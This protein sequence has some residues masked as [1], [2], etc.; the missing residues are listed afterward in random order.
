[1]YQVHA[2]ESL[3][4][5]ELAPYRTMK[6]PIEHERQ[7]IFIAEGEKVVRRLLESQLTIISMLLPAKWLASFAPVLSARPEQIQV[8]VAEKHVLEQ[9]TG[10]SMYQGVLAMARTPP[11]V[12]LPVLLR[13]CP[14]PLFFAAVDG[15]CNAENLGGIVRNCGAF[16][17]QALIVGETSSSPYLRRA[18]RS[19]MGVIFVLPAVEVPSLA[20]SL[21]G[22]REHQVRCVAAHPHADHQDLPSAN[23]AGDCC[24]VF[25]S[26]GQGISAGVLAACDEAIAVPMQSGIDS[27]NV[28]CAS[29]VFLYEVWRQRRPGL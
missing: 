1:M 25:G 16:G 10:Y 6:R 26:E 19:S 7:Q 2:I 8:Y 12:S 27:L 22:L 11:P 28:G 17:V 23:L 9:L 24:L 21:R 18:V 13:T 15:V 29:A 3:E 4:M 14:R 20:D 5:P